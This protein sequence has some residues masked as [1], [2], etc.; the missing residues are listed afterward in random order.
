MVRISLLAHKFR[1]EDQKK[2]KRSSV[3]NHKLSLHVHSS[4]SS[5]NEILLTLS[6]AQAVFWRSTGSEMHS[7]GFGLLLSFGAQ[8][9]LGGTS[10]DLGENGPEIPPWRRAWVASLSTCDV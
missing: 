2:K 6:G 5:W 4:V 7:S 9:S 8:S 10:S 1:G 3:R